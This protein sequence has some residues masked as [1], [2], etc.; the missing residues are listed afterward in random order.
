MILAMLNPAP[1]DRLGRVLI[2]TP[3]PFYED[4]GT[5]IAVQYVARAL[6]E[7]GATVDLLAFPVGQDVDIP[8]VNILRCANPLHLRKVPIGFSWRKL[9][10]DSSLW[11]S[12]TRLVGSA[13]YS[14]VHAVEE[15]AYMASVVCP[16]AGL[17]FIYDMASAIP[18]EMARK[19]AFKAHWIHRLLSGVETRVLRSAT[20]IVCGSGLAPHV[21]RQ[22]P[23][24]QVREW[25][26][27]ALFERADTAKALALRAELGLRD[28]Q[29]VILYSGNV[30]GYQGIGLL[31][32]AFR[33]A[34]RIHPELVLVCVGA[35]A[36]DL[37]P[38]VLQAL[39]S[40]ENVHIVA[41]KP[42]ADMPAWFNS[43][44]YALAR[45]IHH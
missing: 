20:R 43:F 34:Q 5:P 17:P 37:P 6:S 14:V 41:R 28:A 4:R 24:A 36:R 8:N 2:V 10:L 30:A 3:Q 40:L 39:H 18:A 32:D 27:P 42:R 33:R 15:A 7:L 11:Q 45:T 44:C 25:V 23:D 9:A 38:A 12:F 31:L 35:A 1:N 13:N 16:Q 21:S 22:A 19:R 29:R 26:Y